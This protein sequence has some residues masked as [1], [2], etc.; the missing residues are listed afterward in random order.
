MYNKEKKRFEF[1]GFDITIR[2]IISSFVIIAIMLIIGLSISN[3]IS[4]NEME[5][6][7]MY[8]KAIEINNADM[9][10]H[11]MKTNAGNAFVYGELKAVDTVT[12]PEIGGGY[13]YIKKVEEWYERHEKWV[14]DKDEKT[15]KT[16]RK[17]KVWYEW[18]EKNR[19]SEHS[20]QI[21]FCDVVFPYEKIKLPYSR[22]IKTIN[23]GKT[24]SWHSQERIKVR[25][26]YYAI[27]ASYT[28]TIF[29]DLKESTIPVNTNFYENKTTA[30]TKEM[31]Q[32]E[33]GATIFW[34][35]WIPLI[36]LVLFGFFYIDNRWLE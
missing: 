23:A 6:N 33:G 24:Y 19:W 1:D 18:D 8:E 9:F 10:T 15:G 17:L 7:E 2:E 32:S 3:N 26:K 13:L 11:C 34:I 29:A 5:R 4:N 22:H 14:E 12:Y 35:F 27:D 20:E 25:F 21:S 31:L 16:T 28:G 36:C 30:E